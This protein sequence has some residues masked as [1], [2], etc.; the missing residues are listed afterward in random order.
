[1]KCP[2]YAIAD[3]SSLE[4]VIVTRY[5]RKNKGRFNLTTTV[6][7][8]QKEHCFFGEDSAYIR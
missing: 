1:M 2:N 4:H 3:W 7:A 5:C 6:L 8:G